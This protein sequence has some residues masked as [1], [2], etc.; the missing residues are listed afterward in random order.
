[1][2]AQVRFARFR[3]GEAGGDGMEIKNKI[4]ADVGEYI[5][6]SILTRGF[7]P[8]RRKTV[9]RVRRAGEQSQIEMGGEEVR[10][11]NRR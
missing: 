3:A 10:V 6:K 8:G 2:T 9:W 1:M 5:D 4:G 11:G 7:W